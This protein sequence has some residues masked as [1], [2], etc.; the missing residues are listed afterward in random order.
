MSDEN[1]SFSVSTPNYWTPAD[2]EELI[3]E[4]NKLLE[5]RSQK[6]IELHIEEVRKRGNQIKIGAEEYKLSDPD[7]HKIQINKELK[8]VKYK[9]LVYRKELTYTEIEDTLDVKYNA[10]STTGYTLPPGIYEITAINL[11]VNSL[12]PIKVKVKIT[13]DNFRLKSILTLKKNNTVY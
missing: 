4:L 9:D 2:S 1:N 3:N 11:M 7:T 8:S 6:Y 12:L 5:L 10:G 13:I